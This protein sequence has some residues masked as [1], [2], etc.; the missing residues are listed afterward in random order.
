MSFNVTPLQPR[1]AAMR[2][3]RPLRRVRVRLLDGEEIEFMGYA[4]LPAKA[5]T[6]NAATHQQQGV[7]SMFLRA[8][9]RW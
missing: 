5:R 3:E 1:R 2:G 4:C 6:K 9:R 8:W 7:F